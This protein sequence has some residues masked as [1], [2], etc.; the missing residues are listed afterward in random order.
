MATRQIRR[1]DS[2]RVSHAQ[3]APSLLFSRETQAEQAW[4]FGSQAA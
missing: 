2:I 4:G 1:G 3:D